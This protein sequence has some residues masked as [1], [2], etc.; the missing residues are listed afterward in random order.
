MSILSDIIRA[1]VIDGLSDLP[2]T[3]MV[4]QVNQLIDK[5]KN[6]ILYYSFKTMLSRRK[7]NAAVSLMDTHSELLTNPSIINKI[8]DE[9]HWHFQNFWTEDYTMNYW[10]QIDTTNMNMME[11]MVAI[12]GPIYNFIIRHGLKLDPNFH[13]TYY[14]FT[15]IYNQ[16]LTRYREEQ[17]TIVHRLRES[18]PIPQDISEHIIA[19]YIQP[20]RG[21]SKGRLRR[22]GHGNR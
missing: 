8:M 11:R 15:R 19:E 2:E 7:F 9:L 10:Y 4:D 16:T 12:L 13:P 22:R 3:N 20:K 18:L 1:T 5:T 14:L 21:G 6:D 17:K